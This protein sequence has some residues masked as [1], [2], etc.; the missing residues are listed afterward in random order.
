MAIQLFIDK[1]VKK[2]GDVN[3]DRVMN[4]ERLIDYYD[5]IDNWMNISPQIP[6]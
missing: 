2:T 1:Y 5:L 4:G 6:M 3:K